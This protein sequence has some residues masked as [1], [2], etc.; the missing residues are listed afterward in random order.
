MAMEIENK[1]SKCYTCSLHQRKQ[2]KEPMIPHEP[3]TRPWANIGTD[4]F[5]LHNI[6]YICTV[7]YYSKWIEVEELDHLDSRSTVKVLKDQFSKYGIPDEVIS[8]NRPQYACKEFA[9]FAKDYEFL[10]TTSSPTY[11][12]SNGQ[13]ERTIQTV[14]NILEKSD[15]EDPYKGLLNY[16]NTPLD[17]INKSP[18]QL[19]MGRRLKTSLPA[20]AD[21][22]KPPRQEEITEKLKKI[23]EKQKDYYDQKCCSEL[24]L[25]QQGD[26]VRVQLGNEWKPAVVVKKHTTPRSYIIQTELGRKYRRNRRDLILTKAPM[27]DSNAETARIPNEFYQAKVLAQRPETLQRHSEATK[28]SSPVNKEQPHECRYT[29]YKDKTRQPCGPDSPRTS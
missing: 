5:E 15:H 24:K 2:A 13:I 27:S 11:A 7:D 17:G 14:K 9:D 8:D 10:H 4:H 6:H 29:K 3:P 25:L 1:V 18:A 26:Q 20:T 21:L 22:L 12:Q 23:K 19:M 16:R 28:E